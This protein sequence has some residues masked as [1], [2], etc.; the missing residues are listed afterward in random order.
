MRL[1]STWRRVSYFYAALGCRENWCQSGAVEDIPRAY[2][3][4]P[5]R[6]ESV[7]IARFFR[8]VVIVDLV[9]MLFGGT[10]NQR[11]GSSNLPRPIF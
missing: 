10:L 11:V 3:R 2:E 8:I 4:D 7:G 1:R 6:D 9:S 5:R